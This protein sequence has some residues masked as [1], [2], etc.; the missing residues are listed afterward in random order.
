MNNHVKLENSKYNYGWRNEIKK[1]TE[2]ETS[3][4]NR[5]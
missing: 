3:K 1:E 2:I 5:S 4:T